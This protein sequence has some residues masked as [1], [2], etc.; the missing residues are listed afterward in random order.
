MCFVVAPKGMMYIE[1]QHLFS[2]LTRFFWKVFGT[3]RMKKIPFGSVTF[4]QHQREDKCFVA[5]PQAGVESLSEQDLRPES[6][7]KT[8]RCNP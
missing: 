7:L 2:I 4:Q 1:Y 3:L 8:E 6:R 5:L